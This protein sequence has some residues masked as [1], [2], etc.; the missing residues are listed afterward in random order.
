MSQEQEGVI[1]F[2]LEFSEK[3]L[4]NIPDYRDDTL[5]TLNQWRAITYKLELIGQNPDRYLGYGFGNISCRVTNGD[6][7]FLIS[8]TQTGEKS[9]LEESECAIVT[10]C[11]PMKNFIKALGL[12][13]PSSEAM[14]HGQLYLLDKTINAVIHVHSPDIWNYRTELSIPSTDANV[15]YGTPLM[16]KE[17]ERLFNE[18]NVRDQKIFAMTGHEDGVVAFGDSLE[19]ATSILIHYFSNALALKHGTL[20]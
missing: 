2:T 15:P 5:A 17:V 12:C 1:K 7:T 14:T 9:W 16:A 4:K 8:G 6:H 18:T 11:D 20:S 10:H 19:A 3:S 13:K